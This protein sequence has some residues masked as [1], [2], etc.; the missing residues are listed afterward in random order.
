[1][2]LEFL[3]VTGTHVVNLIVVPACRLRFDGS[4]IFFSKVQDKCAVSFLLYPIA[5]LGKIHSLRVITGNSGQSGKFMI[6]IKL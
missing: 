4:L 3:V 5:N 1:V 6:L 2:G